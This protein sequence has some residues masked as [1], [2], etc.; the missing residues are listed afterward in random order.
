MD[1]KFGF[2]EKNSFS[3]QTAPAS[4]AAFA[5][6]EIISPDD[7]ILAN[8]PQLKKF[9]RLSSSRIELWSGIFR[10]NQE[11]IS[12]AIERYIDAIAHIE[13]E[14]SSAP[15][16]EENSANSANSAN[17]VDESSAES[18]S[19]NY[20]K[21]LL[22]ARIAASCLITTVMEAEKKYGLNFARFAGSGFADMTAP[23]A[24]SPDNDIERISK[25]YKE[26]IPLLAQLKS[27]LKNFLKA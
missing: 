11:V 7:I 5:V 22:F 14:L 6:G 13:K 20:P 25:K 3:T 24:D 23:A 12:A 21:E 10:L 9:L 15:Q 19:A 26:I 2:P 18:S 4:R 16:Q 27:E 1:L 8:Y 17:S